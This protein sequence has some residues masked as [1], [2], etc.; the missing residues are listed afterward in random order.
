M[1]PASLWAGMTTEM[2][3]LMLLSL[4]LR[5]G[6]RLCTQ[7]ARLKFQACERTSTCKW[8]AGLIGRSGTAGW[9]LEM[10][11]HAGAE[12]G[13]GRKVDFCPLAVLGALWRAAHVA[14]SAMPRIC[15]STSQYCPEL[16]PAFGYYSKPP[17]N[18]WVIRAAADTAASR[19]CVRC[20][21]LLFIGH[22]PGDL[23][24]GCASYAGKSASGPPWCLPLCRVFRCRPV[25]SPLTCASILW[26]VAPT[27]LCAC[28]LRTAGAGAAAGLA[29]GGGRQCEVRDGVFRDSAALH[30]DPAERRCLC[31]SSHLHSVA[32][33]RLLSHRT[34]SGTLKKLRDLRP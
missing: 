1:L 29:I 8:A 12:G 3:I 6:N 22:G 7:F 16:E 13:R 9:G 5:S 23:W 21:R 20:R 4:A 27:P 28:S 25:S 33:G 24:L 18:A 26:A 19:V 32:R 17:L 30:A 15:S 14:P 34:S 10:G 11:V 31:A 2:R